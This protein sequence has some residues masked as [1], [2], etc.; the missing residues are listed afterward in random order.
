M[1]ITIT[2]LQGR[3]FTSLAA[4]ARANGMSA[5]T[6]WARYNKNPDPEYVFAQTLPGAVSPRM[7]ITDTDGVTYPSLRAAG[8]AH[9]LHQTTVSKR[10]QRNP[11]P[12]YVF[13]KLTPATSGRHGTAVVDAQG[14][15]FRSLRGAAKANNIRTETVYARYRKNTD[16]AFVFGPVAPRTR[17]SPVQDE[18]YTKAMVGWI[19]PKLTSTG[20]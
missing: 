6:A 14:R 3:T 20:E 4:A 15:K 9:G 11:D 19:P 16:P 12:E 17:K 5:G 8:R 2:D 18:T 13:A 10:R 7:P 1:S